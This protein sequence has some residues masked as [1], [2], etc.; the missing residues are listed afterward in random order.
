MLSSIRPRL[1]PEPLQGSSCLERHVVSTSRAALCGP[2][3]QSLA[4]GAGERSEGDRQ[5]MLESSFHRHD[6]DPK[7]KVC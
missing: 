5:S 3:G 4:M 2:C 1:R 6:M 7:Q